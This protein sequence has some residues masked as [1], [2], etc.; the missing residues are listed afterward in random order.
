MID[1][2]IAG[3]KGT[4]KYREG[5]NTE[6]E[7]IRGFDQVHVVYTEFECGYAPEGWD[8]A[9]KYLLRMGFSFEELE[10]AGISKMGKRGPI[11]RFHRRLLWPIKDLSGHVIGFGASK[12]FD[13]DNLGKY[14]NT[15][16]TML[17]HK[18]LARAETND[19]AG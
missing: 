8:T 17:Y 1:G 7:A 13:E 15:P 11:D 14:M 2:F 6:G 16:E 9:T 12:L 19:V 4:A 5:I 10:A 3:S 18:K